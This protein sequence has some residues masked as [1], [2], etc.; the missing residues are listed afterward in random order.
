MVLVDSSPPTASDSHDC[1]EEEIE[2]LKTEMM[3]KVYLHMCVCVCVNLIF[4]ELPPQAPY[5][6]GSLCDLRLQTGGV[7]HLRILLVHTLHLLQCV[8]EVKPGEKCVI[9]LEM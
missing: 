6:L 4:G 2:F 3:N 5:V 8:T 7:S 1:N 9:V